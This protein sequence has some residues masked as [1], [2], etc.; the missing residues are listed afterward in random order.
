MLSTALSSLLVGI[1]Q[2]TQ[3]PS[4]AVPV[5]PLSQGQL[6]AG[7]HSPSHKEST[8]LDDSDQ[9]EDCPEDIEFSEDEGL[10]PDTPA[11]SGFFRPSL[12]KSLL[13]KARVTTNLGTGDSHLS[14]AQSALGPHDSL[15]KLTKPDKD[16]IPCPQLFSEVIQNPWT[17]P[18]S[19]TAP[20]SQDKRLYCAAPELE[21]MLTLPVVDAPVANL[22][23]TSVLSTD[24]LDGL[25]ADDRRA[26]LA[27]RKAH[28]ATSWA[29]RTAT[30][31]SFFNRASLIWLRQL[32]EQ[33]PPEEMRLHQDIN[34]IVAATEYSA[35]ASLNSVKFASRALVSTITSR[36]LFWL[37]GWKAAAKA[38]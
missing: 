4:T 34:K 6:P 31:T 9:G 27:F 14:A 26:E 5:Q 25:K 12:F 13:H 11:F 20:S 30:A 35:D 38:R 15:F 21:D 8:S 10:L 1:Q 23:S 18:G 28:Q 16:C 2:T 32:Q 24:S 22:S 7:S 17:Q 29:I 36:R 19:L 33:L 3:L 37:W